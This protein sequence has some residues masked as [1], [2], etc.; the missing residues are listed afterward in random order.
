[1]M[2]KKDTCRHTYLLIE[3]YYG[4]YRVSQKMPPRFYWFQQLGGIFLGHPVDLDTYDTQIVTR[5]DLL[6]CR[7]PTGISEWDLE[8]WV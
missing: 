1:M 2:I 3:M 5:L 6:L 4:D 8:I 7:A